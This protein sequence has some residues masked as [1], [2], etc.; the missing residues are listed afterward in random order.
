MDKIVVDIA[1]EIK[2][3]NTMIE[4]NSYFINA[5]KNKIANTYICPINP[6]IGVYLDNLIMVDID[7]SIIPITPE[8]SPIIIDKL[9]KASSIEGSIRIVMEYKC[10]EYN[11]D[12]LQEYIDNAKYI[13]NFSG[14][15]VAV[16]SKIPDFRSS[17]GLY[18]KGFDGKSPEEILSRKCFRE[19]PKLF[20]KFLKTRMTMF[21]GKLPN[22]SHLFLAQLEKVGKL[23]TIITQN[24]DGLHIDAGNT[25]VLEIHG[26]HRTYRCNSACGTNY[27][28]DEFLNKLNNSDIPLCECGGIIRTNTVLFDEPLD[29]D[30]FEKAIGEC[31]KADLM[32]VVASTLIVQPAAS[33]LSEINKDC[34]LVIINNDWT[35]YDRK[36][37]LVIRENC[38]DVFDKIK[39]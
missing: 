19:N 30:T 18:M 2:L 13:V 1:T 5:I 38:G 33:L 17:S 24:I 28:T 29:D 27:T 34:K 6:N 35:P 3:K 10:S 14:A 20:F 36:A 31:K 11:I 15:G 23:K 8:Q 37:D 22:R 4:Y 32:L 7:S 21:D 12:K 9:N 25:N 26:T 39:L 16:E